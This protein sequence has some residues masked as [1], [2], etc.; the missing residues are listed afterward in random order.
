MDYQFLKIMVNPIKL[1]DM[2]N[3]NKIKCNL[4]KI[5]FMQLYNSN[6]NHV[7]KYGQSCYFGS[8]PCTGYLLVEQILS[9]YIVIFATLLLVCY[10]HYFAQF[11]VILT[12]LLSLLLF[13]LHCYLLGYSQIC[14]KITGSCSYLF[15][16]CELQLSHSEY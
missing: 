12:T 11:A 16:I 1:N 14:N 4:Y 9:S 8:V 5:S 7:K 13:S 2:D 6:R 3:F 15:L 10:F